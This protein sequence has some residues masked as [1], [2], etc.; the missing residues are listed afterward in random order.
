MRT[1]VR[2]DGFTLIELLVSVAILGIVTLVVMQAFTVQQHTYVVTDQV[3]ESQQNMRAVADL[4]ERDVRLAGYMVSPHAAV[5]GDDETT[6]PD[7]FF[8]SN[9]GAIRTV[10]QL[11]G[12]G[13]DLAGSYGAEVTGVTSS[14]GLSG[15]AAT[16]TLQQ[17]WVDVAADGPD[18]VE[19]GGVIFVD[20]RN[21]DGLVAC[22]V[23]T[24]IGGNTLTVDLGG[25]SI[26]PVGFNADVV[27]IPAHAYT[28]TS[29]TPRELRRNGALLASDVEDF[30][31][32]YFFDL[33]DDRVVD[34]GET[35]GAAGTTADP[36]GL[37]PAS[38]RP[39]F[40]S[41]REVDL[42]FV[43]ATRSDDPNEAFTLGA[44]QVIGNRTVGSLVAS[45]G[46]R[47]RVHTA[48]VRL[49]NHG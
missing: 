6:A 29:G 17:L 20:R 10:F 31:V 4:L 7:R 45:D 14:W 32:A 40:S 5:C 11:E 33:N 30:Q 25:T 24:N 18:F 21:E 49:R 38:N 48:R 22:G 16:A 15:A 47:R 26:G 3:T 36:Y 34:A 35:F 12:G 37:S 9:A 23:I 19:G 28:V 42:S 43:V 44:G 2:R 41:L 8:V 13:E 27:A 1:T 46:K 39:D